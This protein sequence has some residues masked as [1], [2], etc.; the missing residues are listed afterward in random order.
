MPI[1]IVVAVL[2]M[3][4]VFLVDPQAINPGTSHHLVLLVTWYRT[5]R[6]CNSS[7]LNITNFPRHLVKQIT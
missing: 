4:V 2:G 5:S 3:F 1:L 6:A 7:H